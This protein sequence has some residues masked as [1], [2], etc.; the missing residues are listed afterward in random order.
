MAA[1]PELLVRIEGHLDDIS[2]TLGSI[3]AH[4][5]QLAVIAQTTAAVH[6]G[7]DP[8]TGIELEPETR[9]RHHGQEDW[10]NG[11]EE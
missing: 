3:D 5:E 2:V 1:D 11:E 4:L 6:L 9:A 10:L 8:I 7:F